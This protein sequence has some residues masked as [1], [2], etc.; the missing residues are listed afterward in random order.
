MQGVNLNLTK[1]KTY[2][3]VGA[4]GSGKTTLANM[5]C[6]FYQSDQGRILIDGVPLEDIQ[7]REVRA[8]I[9]LVSQ[10]VHLFDDTIWDNIRYGNFER[11]PTDIEQVVEQVG[12]NGLDVQ[13]KIG[14]QGVQL[15]GRPK[16]AYRPSADPIA[17]GGFA[18]LGRSYC[19]AGR[20]ERS[21]S[22]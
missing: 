1:G 21:G 20:R 14:E 13:A 15:S 2:A 22:F 9:G 3:L 4:S 5:L 7:L 10:Q 16:A 12:L 19:C 17:A 18:H 11:E 6:S 8:H